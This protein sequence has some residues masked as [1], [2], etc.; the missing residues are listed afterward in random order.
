LR[1]PW[2][3]KELPPFKFNLFVQAKRPSFRTR[4]TKQYRAHG[5]NSPYWRFDVVPHQQTA[6]KRLKEFVGRRAI[7][8]YA[9]PA[10]HLQE[11][12]YKRQ[13]N[14]DIVENSS[15]PDV[16]KL[17]NHSAWSFSEPGARGVAN[18][19]PESSDGPSLEEQISKLLDRE[20][21]DDR[22]LSQWIK[23]LEYLA[24]AVNHA[25]EPDVEKD[26]AAN[27]TALF[28]QARHRSAL[29]VAERYIKQLFGQ[30]EQRAMRSFLAVAFFSQIMK[31]DWS[32]AGSLKHRGTL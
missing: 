30:Q 24:K 4:L 27:E 31:L 8:C 15:F 17:V 26:A 29:S 12:L 13:V 21:E 18:S 7:V 11:E 28:L 22:G 19:I 5:L 25:L 6:L 20:I 1:E 16:L 14:N 23:N 32:V 3:T 2:P 9:C 10:F